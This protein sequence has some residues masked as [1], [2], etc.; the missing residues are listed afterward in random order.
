MDRRRFLQGLAAVGAAATGPAFARSSEGQ[1]FD[2]AVATAPWLTPFKGAGETIQDLRCDALALSGRWPAAL[3]GRFYRNGP[4]VFERD[5]QRYHHWFAGDGM[6]QQFTVAG[7]ARPAL[8]HVGRLVRTPKYLAEQQAGR[9]LY[10]A[11]GT[12]IASDAVASGPDSVNVAN[13]NAIEHAGRVLAMWEGGSAFALDPADLSTRGP[14][15]WR[16]DLEQM[17]FSAHPK[18]DADGHLWN[19]GSSGAKLVVW[20]V[21][22]RGALVSAQVG[23]SP[24]PGGMA[25]DAAITARYIVLPLPPIRL[26]FGA[27]V[28]AAFDYQ[29][30]EPLR[31]LVMHKDD[32]QQRRVFE[33]PAAMVFHVG[34]AWEQP[35]G[36]VVLSYVASQTP[37][38]AVHGASQ[39]LAGHPASVGSTSTHVA[40]LDMRT[41]RAS[42]EAM[43]D[44][45][46]FPRIH[47]QRIGLPARY[48]LSTAS[49]SPDK[50]GLFH[51]VQLR[52]LETGRVAHHDYGRDTIAEEHILVPKPDASAELDA[53]LLGT[54]FDVRRQVTR[55]N[56]LDARHVG[57]GPIAQATLPYGLAYGFH[58]NFTPA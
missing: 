4:A 32:I 19:F 10:P 2:D 33:L 53:W 27:D 41:G 34:N 47:P 3:R 7:G 11:Y 5:G 12:R 46:E 28:A 8:R 17:P 51:G 9:F 24:Y 55:V 6:V 56:L 23:D 30:G 20:H 15:T 39:L 48:L 52:D 45:V 14:V 37:E 43:G 18:V 40:R 31:I 22:P 16:P 25:H 49:P 57:D 26:R 35:D 36:S 54:T 58:G 13:T 21:D 42:V 1:A 50:R 29:P 38:F 44:E